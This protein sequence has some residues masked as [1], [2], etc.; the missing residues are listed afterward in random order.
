MKK[1]LIGMLIFIMLVCFVNL[2]SCQNMKSFLNEN[3]DE[4]K[5]V[6]KDLIGDIV[7][8]IFKELLNTSPVNMSISRD[9]R[10]IALAA[11]KERYHIQTDA[12]LIQFKESLKTRILRAIDAKEINCDVY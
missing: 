8:E 7:D 6:I 2:Q 11:I 4:L 9:N 5:A 3:K 12:D 1:L 10:S